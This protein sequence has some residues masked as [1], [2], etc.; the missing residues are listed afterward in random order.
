MRWALISVLLLALILVP[1]LLF[2]DFFNALAARFASGE[3]SSWYAAIG[4]GGL[5]ASDVVLPIPS[6]IVS[7]AAGVLLGFAGGTAVIWVGMTISCGIGYWIGARSAVPI[8]F[9]SSNTRKK[10]ICGR[11]WCWMP[12]RRCA[13]AAAR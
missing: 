10:A 6:S 3:G 2:E 9:T 4:I 1:F 5:L 13:M 12:A 7:A 8:G 11:P